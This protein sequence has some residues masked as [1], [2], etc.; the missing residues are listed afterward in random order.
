MIPF[1]RFVLLA[2]EVTYH[3]SVSGL[4]EVSAPKQDLL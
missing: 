1:I 3:F 4:L 2:N